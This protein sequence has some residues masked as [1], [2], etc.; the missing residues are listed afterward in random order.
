MGAVSETVE[1]NAQTPMVNAVAGEQRESVTERHLQELPLSRRNVQNILVLG[2]GVDT[3][4]G[5]GVRLNGLGR[6]GVKITVDGTDATSNRENPGTAMY[7]SFNYINV[8]RIEAVQE[9]QT[10]KGVTAAEYANQLSG[11]VNLITS[12]ARTRSMGACLKVSGRKT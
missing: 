4:D 12:P 3:S 6:S 8:M 11:D 5:G 2:T 1:V 9:V 10:V 7:Q